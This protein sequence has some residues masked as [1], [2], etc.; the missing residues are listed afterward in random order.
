MRA[1]KIYQAEERFTKIAQ[2]I[3]PAEYT[4]VT[5]EVLPYEDIK[6]KW[7]KIYNSVRFIICDYMCDAP[8][9]VIEE[10]FKR[11]FAKIN[12]KKVPGYTK[13]AEAYLYGNEFAEK[14]RESFLNRRHAEPVA[15]DHYHGIPVHIND[16]ERFYSPMMDVIICDPHTFAKGGSEYTQFLDECLIFRRKVRGE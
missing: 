10:I 14:N 15:S 5:V 8:D 4:K 6:V 3:A 11:T 13:K 7:Q 2:A 1:E 12:G 16:E 9:Y